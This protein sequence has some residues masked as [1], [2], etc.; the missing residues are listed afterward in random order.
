MTKLS[1]LK[2]KPGAKVEDITLD[3]WVGKEAFGLGCEVSTILAEFSAIDREACLRRLMAAIRNW[4]S[5]RYG[6]DG[7]G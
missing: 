7:R 6:V 1:R 5:Y 4:H 2:S 3:E